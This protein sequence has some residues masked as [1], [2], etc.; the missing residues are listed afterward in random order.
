MKRIL[1]QI[2]ALIFCGALTAQETASDSLIAIG[3]EASGSERANTYYKLSSQL[4]DSLPDSALFY[5]NQ[6]ELILL[7]GDPE[8]LLPP[9][10]KLKGEI[11]EEIMVTD[12]SLSY[13]R[14]AY[15]EFIKLGNNHEV[16]IC[17]LNLG[18]IYYELGD[19]S[20]AYF[21]FMQSL[22]AY[23]HDAD[24]KGIAQMENNLGIVAHEMGKLNE[25][26][27]HYLK[28]YDIYQE[29]GSLSDEC[30]S[31]NNIGLILYDRQYYDSALVYF[32][33]AIDLLSEFSDGSDT[34]QNTLSS[35]Y[36]NMALAYSDIEEYEKALTCLLK[37]L[38]LARKA[39]DIYTIGSVYTNLGSIYGKMDR[40]DSALFYLHRSLK[41][42]KDM[43]FR[44]LELEVYNELSGLHA[45]L[46]SYASAYNWRLRYDTVYKDLFNENQSQEIA[47]IR[48]LY[49]QQIKDRQIEQLN[50]QSQVQR[51][52][53]KV[54]IVFIVVIGILIIIITVN[55][56]LKKRANQMLAERN[57]Q[58]SSA[59]EKLSQS[60]EE[61]ETLN[62]SKDRIFSV[63]AHDLRNPVAAVTGF[64]ELLYENFEEFPVETQKEYL[65]QIV[66]GTQRV[67]NLLENLLVWARSQMKAI[68]YEPEIIKVKDV[69]DECV[70]E[71][72]ANL[73]HKKVSCQVKVEKNCEVFADKYMVHTVFLNL[74]I[75]AVKFSFPGGRIWIG[76]VVTPEGWS[77][78][79]TDEGIGIQPEIQEKLFDSNEGISSPGTSGE[80]GSGLGLVICHEFMEQNRGSIR[81]ESEPGNGST[82]FVTLPASETP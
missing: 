37:G 59:M 26:E 82:F 7:K 57:L 23:E 12:R 75:N 58:I 16:G 41:I 52:L 60:G 64:S 43:K 27:R 34:D 78:S 56:R 3:L 20:E 5:A 79:V 72:K 33:E 21:F 76:S 47:R 50:S 22:N 54:F 63:V 30:R 61:M 81:V 17:A 25:A 69:V 42:A 65:L 31:L 13:Y 67:Q 4:L 1:L 46:G 35:L 70:Q 66:Q 14:K 55:L 19:F 51:T 40:Q 36:N 80:L 73:D 18:N 77:V 44:H 24:M 15:D 38:A 29:H 49:E 32:R 53:N 8:D 74:I 6:A 28:A 71:L 48:G 2:I 68:K 62:R 10:F 11:Y 9:L 39:D 45:G